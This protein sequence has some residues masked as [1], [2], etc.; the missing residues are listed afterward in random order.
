MMRTHVPNILLFGPNQRATDK[1]P[2][3]K[4]SRVGLSWASPP[5]LVGARVALAVGSQ[6]RCHSWTEEAEVTSGRVVRALRDFP[7]ISAHCP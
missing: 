2:F 5:I 1:G 3:G 4:S 6:A 7:T